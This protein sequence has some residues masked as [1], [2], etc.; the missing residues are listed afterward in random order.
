M[1]FIRPNGTK[2]RSLQN[3]LY[4]FFFPVTKL[5]FSDLFYVKFSTTTMQ[6]IIKK[7]KKKKTLEGGHTVWTSRMGE[8]KA[9]FLREGRG[10]R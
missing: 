8:E 4:D 6:C 5:T 7:K 2:G 1:C 9:I 3:S 10:E